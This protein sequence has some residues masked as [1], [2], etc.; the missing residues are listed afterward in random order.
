MCTHTCCC[1]C[2]AR[3][4]FDFAIF[5][6]ACFVTARSPLLLYTPSLALSA[7]APL[8]AS[9]CMQGHTRAA[10]Q[11]IG[12]L[13][14]TSRLV[15]AMLV[16]GTCARRFCSCR[17]LVGRG[18]TGAPG[19]IPFVCRCLASWPAAAWVPAWVDPQHARTCGAA[20]PAPQH[21]VLPYHARCDKRRAL[22][23]IELGCFWFGAASMR[24][25]PRSSLHFRV[26]LSA[27]LTERPP[28][29]TVC[30]CL[31]SFV[32][33]RSK[34]LNR[35]QPQQLSL[36]P[37]LVPCN[38]CCCSSPGT[39]IH[40]HT[41]VPSCAQQSSLIRMV[42]TGGREDPSTRNMRSG[43]GKQVVS[44]AES[45]PEWGF[46]TGH[47]DAVNKLVGVSGLHACCLAQ[48]AV[49]WPSTAFLAHTHT[50]G[51]HTRSW[52]GGGRGQ[53][54]RRQGGWASSCTR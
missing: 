40:T 36:G 26:F 23:G 50:N 20:G 44:Q 47:R 35:P 22:C 12:A 30:E 3:C 28:K 11:Y 16:G 43:F 21:C 2:L 38:S 9:A 34:D 6:F 54:E 37:P 13:P 29:P 25:P 14:A 45:N 18:L 8:P 51:M 42:L 33:P 39:H 46:G 41:S 31:V 49:H 32:R 5:A 10:P 19:V 53:Q 1:R 15:C 4:S 48:P 52:G 17:S 27:A 7:P 24:H